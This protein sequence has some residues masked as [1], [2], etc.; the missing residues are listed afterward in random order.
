MLGLTNHELSGSVIKFTFICP[1]IF[2]YNVASEMTAYIKLRNVRQNNLKGFDLDIPLNRLIVITGLSGAG[3]SSLAFET[4]FAEGQ[5]RYIETF[6]PYARQFLDRMDR[7]QVDKIENI[8]PAIA[9]AHRNVVRSSRSTVG[10]LTDICDYMKE[11][12]P[13]VANLV[14]KRCGKEVVKETP[15]FIW[16]ELIKNWP[17][18]EVMITFI[19]PLTQR[20]SLEETVELIGKQ[21]YQRLVWKGQVIGLDQWLT[22]TKASN[23][24]AIEIVQDR[25]RISPENHARFIESVEQAY[26]F[27]KGQIWVHF[28]KGGSEPLC[29]SEKLHCAS[30]DI[31]YEAP[32]KALFSFNHPIGA[33]P[34]CKGFGRVIEIDYHRAIPNRS[35]TLRECP[36]EP[37]RSG[38]GREC[39]Y[40]MLKVCQSK[41]IPLDVPFKALDPEHQRFIIEGDP[42]YGIDSDHEWPYCWYG[43]R[44]YFKW[45]ETKSYKLHIRVLLS[46]YRVYRTCPDCKGT[47]FKEQALFYKLLPRNKEEEKFIPKGGLTIGEFYSLSLDKALEVIR[48]IEKRFSTSLFKNPARIAAEEIRKRLE[49]LNEVGLEYLTLDRAARTL[50]G[51][52]LERVTMAAALGSELVNTLYVLDEPTVGLHPRDV[53]RLV[54][55]LTQLRDLGN[56]V[57]VVEHELNIIRK[58]DYVIELGPGHGKDG[59]YVVFQGSIDRL[60]Q[61]GANSYTGKYLAG[62]SRIDPPKQRRPVSKDDTLS[63]IKWL[64]IRHVNKHNLK[65][66]TVELPLNRFVCI[67]GVSGSGKSTLVRDIIVPTLSLKLYGKIEDEFIEKDVDEIKEELLEESPFQYLEEVEIE[68]WEYIKHVTWVDQSP[69][70]ATPRSTPALYVDALDYIRKI[71][72]S[73]EAAQIA[74]LRTSSFSFNSAQG[75]CPRCGGLGFEKVEM[76]FLTDIYIKCPDCDGRRYKPEVLKV[77][78]PIPSKSQSWNIADFLEATIEEA[79]DVLQAIGGTDAQEAIKRLNCLKLVGLGYLKM[80]QPLNTLSGGENERIKLARYLARSGVFG[81]SKRCN[82]THLFL[83]DEPTTGLHLEDLKTLIALFQYLV[84]IGHSVVVIEHNPYLIQCADW[85]ID[86]G[87]EGGE[88]GGKII[89][90]GP[91]EKIAGCLYS[92]T[93]AALRDI[94][95]KPSKS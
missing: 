78:I 54:K 35:L 88:K 39:Y 33:C 24:G 20:L 27:G 80:G 48:L 37:W 22:Q 7:P 76:Q 58:A 95:I 60:I 31:E 73:T 12:W 43:L 8:P 62:H 61:N 3:K 63:P 81:S 18:S 77:R 83:F 90:E 71:L 79:I 84:D 67:T 87:P 28:L 46:K 85:V 51:G 16:S 74:G 21:G 2:S 55:I 40:D 50:S 56:T 57:V 86:L 41:N 11:L 5:R 47:R 70:G 13:Y 69:V 68:G 53:N 89:C 59:G 66:L 75:R 19:L 94:G 15:E 92:Y 64:I 6:S 38:I 10:T 91:P 25:I 32:T 14:C 44:G 45:L 93:G 29:F 65:D 1:S 49:Y 26:R 82:Q 34:R 9:I 72:A 36:I 52:E 42:N 4:L 30:C 17:N 23:P